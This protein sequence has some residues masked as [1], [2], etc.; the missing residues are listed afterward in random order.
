MARAPIAGSAFAKSP[1]NRSFALISAK[2]A[3]KLRGAKRQRRLRPQRNIV[4]E[5]VGHSSANAEPIGTRVGRASVSATIS[6][7]AGTR[8]IGAPGDD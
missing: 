1:L 3:C 8:R 2:A 4:I 5:C 7:R 6:E